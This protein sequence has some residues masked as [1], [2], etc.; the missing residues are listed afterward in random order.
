MSL[1]TLQVGQCGNQLGYSFFN[2][3]F[4]ISSQKPNAANCNFLEEVKFRFFSD[5]E[6]ENEKNYAHAILIDTESKVIK[7]IATSQKDIEWSYRDDC[8]INVQQL[9]SGN[10]WAMGYHC[11]GPELQENVLNAIHKETE[12]CDNVLGFLLFSS[13]AGGTGSGFGSY[14]SEVVRD[15]FPSNSSSSITVWPFQRG[16]VSVQAYNATL[17]LASLQKSADAVFVFEN[18]WLM[19]L[20][21]HKMGLK[22]SSL[23][24][25]NTVASQQ[26]ANLLFPVENSGG[27]APVFNDLLEHLVPHP[28]FKLVGLRS[29]PQEPLT[30][31]PFSA[32]TWPGLLRSLRRMVLYNTVIDEVYGQCSSSTNITNTPPISLANLLVLRGRDS[33]VADPELLHK[34]S[35][36]YASWVP[37]ALRLKMWRHSSPFLPY[38]RTAVLANNGQLSVSCVN[39]AVAKAWQLFSYKAYFHHYEQ[40][41]LSKEEFKL[42]VMNVEQIIASYKALEV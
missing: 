27:I 5:Y 23:N 9:G 1:I 19:K 16:E 31:L 2:T 28:Q 24:D 36:P 14:I 3:I 32:Y 12:R 17:S 29:V 20:C 4:E 21:H 18:D 26:L 25:L 22:K 42:A 40:C 6:K 10:N 8:L 38:D 34:P 33:E 13:V 11:H 7:E 35:L 39:N 30:S 37:N 15:N 41:G